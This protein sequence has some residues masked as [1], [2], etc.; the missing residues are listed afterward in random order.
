MTT[1]SLVISIAAGIAAI[2]SAAVAARALREAKKANALPILLDFLREYRQY[3]PDRR[4][5]LRE[6]GALERGLGIS[7]L[8]DEPRTHARTVCHYLDQLGLLV[9]KD[10]VDQNDVAGVMG[11]SILYSWRAL[12]PFIT[13]EREAR[14]GDYAQYFE[15]LVARVLKIGPRT[16]R[17]ELETVPAD[18]EL[19][20]PIVRQGLD[21]GDQKEA[22]S[23]DGGLSGESE[24]VVELASDDLP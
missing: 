24:V 15:H 17:A 11:E 23:S 8:P 14:S 6:L 20:I 19:P 9:K 5:I 10:L 1:V 18:A 3:E 13:A 7:E 22:S 12:E 21:D 2:V 16:P 4:Y